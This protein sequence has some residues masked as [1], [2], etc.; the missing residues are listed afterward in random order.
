MIMNGSMWKWSEYTS[1]DPYPGRQKLTANG[2]RLV[3]W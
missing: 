1:Q 3:V 2:E